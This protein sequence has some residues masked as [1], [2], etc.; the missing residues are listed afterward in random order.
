[1]VL[2]AV[3]RE[4]TFSRAAEA[5]ANGALELIGIIDM[6]RTAAVERHVVGNVDQR[7]DRTEASGLQA[8]LHPRRRR[9]VLHPLHEPA[10]EHGA[11]ALRFRCELEPNFNG[12]IEGPLDIANL[13]FRLQRAETSGGQITR[14]ATYTRAVGPIR[15][16][17]D[18]NDR[19]VKADDIDVPLTHALAEFRVQLN[20]ALVVVGQLEPALGAEHAV[21]D[22]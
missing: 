3:E 10:R 4:E 8:A 17:L 6:E 12:T 15:R 1:F 16:E 20:D 2:L 7:A 14:D 13:G 22:D 9:A 18:L 11:R 5:G 19:I 21:P